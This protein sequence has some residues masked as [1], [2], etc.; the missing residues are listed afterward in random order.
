[1]GRGNQVKGLFYGSFERSRQARSP[2]SEAQQLIFRFFAGKNG[3]EW[4]RMGKNGQEDVFVALEVEAL[5]N[6]AN[7]NADQLEAE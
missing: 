5:E 4:A 1:M 3:Q 6:S 7:L 2:I